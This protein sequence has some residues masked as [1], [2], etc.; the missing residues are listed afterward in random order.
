MAARR[1]I[2]S[3]MD[4]SLSQKATLSWDVLQSA[5]KGL[6]ALREL[7]LSETGRLAFEPETTF[8]CSTPKCLLRNRTESA[9][10]NVYRRVFNHVVGSPQSGTKVLQVPEFYGD[11]LQS[12]CDDVCQDCAEVWWANLRKKAWVKLPEVF[13]LRG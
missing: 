13:G 4:T 6:M 10:L 5:M 11:E 7:E 9:A 3:L 8:C 12:I 2:D 1:G